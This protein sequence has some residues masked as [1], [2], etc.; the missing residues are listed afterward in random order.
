MQLLWGQAPGIVLG[1]SASHIRMAG[2]KSWLHF[3]FQFPDNV[4]PER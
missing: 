1:T 3:Q 4:Y 2:F